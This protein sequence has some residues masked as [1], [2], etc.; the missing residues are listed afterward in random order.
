M[1]LLVWVLVLML[2]HIQFMHCRVITIS[3]LKVLETCVIV[4]I[5]RLWQAPAPTDLWTR[6]LGWLNNTVNSVST[7]G[8]EL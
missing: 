4:G 7:A 3:C 6:A 8:M 1:W 5:M 2:V